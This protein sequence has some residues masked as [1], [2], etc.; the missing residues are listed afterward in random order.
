MGHLPAATYA[1]KIILCLW[2]LPTA[3]SSSV[4]GEP[5]RL[6]P[7]FNLHSLISASGKEHLPFQLGHVVSVGP[8][9]MGN[10]H[11]KLFLS[12]FIKAYVSHSAGLLG[13]R[14]SCDGLVH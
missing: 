8:L 4:R 9:T 2:Q 13:D 3:T 5:M 11:D 14:M 1:R 12:F 7:P 6:S 10:V